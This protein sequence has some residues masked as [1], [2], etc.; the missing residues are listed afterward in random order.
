[1]P[2]PPPLH[3]RRLYLALG[4]GT[5]TIGLVLYLT[6]LGL[7]WAARDVFGDALWAAMM[8]WWVS[9]LAPNAPLPARAGVALTACFGVEWSQ[10]YHSPS[11]DALRRTTAGH[12]VLGSGFDP[13]DFAS[14]TAGVLAAA[15]IDRAAG[16]AR[17]RRHPAG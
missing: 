9:T 3:P 8:L 17:I 4:L 11:F 13:R 14:Y 15:T 12:L 5:V 2:L 7:P 6:G 16:Y 1:M 10:L